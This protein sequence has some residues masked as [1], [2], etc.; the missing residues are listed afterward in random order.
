MRV[1]EGEFLTCQ[2]LHTR[3]YPEYEYTGEMMRTARRHKHNQQLLC[4]RSARYYSIIDL[5]FS[6]LQ[7]M[8][9]I[10]A[11]NEIE[12]IVHVRA[13]ARFACLFGK[14]GINKENCCCCNLSC[15][16]KRLFLFLRTWN[17]QYQLSCLL[18]RCAPSNVLILTSPF[19]LQVLG[20]E[21][22]IM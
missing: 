19:F 20:R 16:G 15:S 7:Y 12:T 1:K 2:C 3:A 8:L 9:H 4:A 10:V 13:H 11:S 18:V 5:G 6:D 14:K 21:C 17:A 22:S